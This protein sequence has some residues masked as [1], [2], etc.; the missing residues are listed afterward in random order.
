MRKTDIYFKTG[1]LVLACREKTGIKGQDDIYIC[2]TTE[3]GKVL[4]GLWKI[5]TFAWPISVMSGEKAL[6]MPIE[7]LCEWL[8]TEYAIFL[9]RGE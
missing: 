7:Q 1:P 3:R 5:R 9:M 8:E 4:F 2:H 6:E